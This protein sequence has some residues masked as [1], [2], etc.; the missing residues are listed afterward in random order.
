MGDCVPFLSGSNSHAEARG[1][2]S[3]PGQAGIGW[4]DAPLRRA[5]MLL[6][7]DSRHDILLAKHY[8]I[9]SGGFDC[10]LLTAASA[11]Q[12]METLLR[13]HA[14]GRPIDLI[15]LDINMPGDGG[16]ALLTRIRDHPVLRKIQVIMCTGSSLDL[17]RRRA[18]HLGIV[19]YV[20]KPPSPEKLREIVESLPLFEV[21]DDGGGA[22][23]MTVLADGPAAG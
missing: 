23:L 16:F 20:V 18:R 1:E 6:V 14:D 8:L 19:G 17:D 13:A 9:E 15:L 22:R 2:G 3:A 5:R 21:E 12:A 7:D 11:T 4:R 10:E